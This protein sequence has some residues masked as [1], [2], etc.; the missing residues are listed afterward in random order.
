MKDATLG[1]LALIG[2][3][4]LILVCGIGSWFW[5]LGTGVINRQVN[6]DAIV[7]NYEWYEQQFR[8][9]QAVEGQIKDAQEA[10]T[11]LM[12]LIG[13]KQENWTFDQRQELYRL[14]S[15]LTGLKQS[16]RS[17]I[18]TYNARASMVTSNMWKNSSLPHQIQ[19]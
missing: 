5:N 3:C 9:I 1:V 18:Q 8:D 15:N 16:R 7:S 11:R 17:M 6:P 13:P 2:I 4:V 10:T 12:N 14:E 19:E